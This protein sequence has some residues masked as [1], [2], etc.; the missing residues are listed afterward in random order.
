ML[1]VST[2]GS[3]NGSSGEGHAAGL[4]QCP[5]RGWSG[6]WAAR[7][8]TQEVHSGAAGDPA[9]NPS[10]LVAPLCPLV[11]LLCLVSRVSPQF[12]PEGAQ[13]GL[14]G[15]TTALPGTRPPP[16]PAAPSP[17]F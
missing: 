14:E 16:P 15:L 11:V 6:G 1:S 4:A 3:G 13:H 2:L 8:P 17:C 10:P 7:T 12:L 9:E 5:G